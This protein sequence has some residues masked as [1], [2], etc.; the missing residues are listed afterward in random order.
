VRSEDKRRARL[1]VIRHL[2]DH[3]TYE[4]IP[5]KKVKLP[6]RQLPENYKEA[7]HPFTFVPEHDWPED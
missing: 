4:T 7:D 1:N 3:I 5:T 6:K 2:L